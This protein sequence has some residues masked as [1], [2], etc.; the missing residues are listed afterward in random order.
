M[1]PTNR[2]T[3]SLLERVPR[4]RLKPLATTSLTSLTSLTSIT[5]LTALFCLPL[6]AAALLS[7]ALLAP[8]RSAAHA[9]SPVSVNGTPIDTRLF[10]E[11]F[12]L[13]R[14]SDKGELSEPKRLKLAARA[15]RVLVQRLLV[16]GELARHGLTVKE[17]DVSKRVA[18]M[19]GT[20]PNKER[21]LDYLSKQGLTEEGFRLSM[22]VKQG[23]FLLL[24]KDGELKPTRE[25]LQ[26]RYNT[27]RAQFEQP[28][29]FHARQ[30]LLPLPADAPAERVQE[31]FKQI[32]EVHAIYLEGK[33]NFEALVARYSAG[34]LRHR[35]G[36]IG[37]FARGELVDTIERAVLALK[38]G[39][40]SSPVR[41][42]FGWHILQRL[43]TTPERKV[44]LEEAAPGLTPD[45]EQLN[46]HNKM[47]PYLRELL[48]KARLETDLPIRF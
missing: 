29:R 17:E 39:E 40:V 8:A 34:P 28:E 24:Q 6:T 14:G 4:A 19:V 7:P 36:D 9:Q 47:L 10:N 16:Q 41:S 23:V 30:V 13:L 15:A 48:A 46:F 25:Q 45:V 31:V 38:E 5:A 27:L 33:L 2:N 22:W 42:P 3:F 18:Q 20:F 21:Y 26:A 43:D 44:T 37:Y 35:K 11:H 32:Q 12:A 1:S